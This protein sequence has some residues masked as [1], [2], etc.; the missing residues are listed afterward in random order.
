MDR[1]KCL[2]A[3]LIVVRVGADDVA[4]SGSDHAVVHVAGLDDVAQRG[5]EIATQVRERSRIVADLSE[6]LN[7]SR[8]LEQAGLHARAELAVGDS[9]G[10]CA[11]PG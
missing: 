11:K 6:L 8:E 4:E 10:G 9:A 3:G 7:A 2:R 1:S 5:L